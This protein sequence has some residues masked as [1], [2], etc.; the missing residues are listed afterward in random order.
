[1]RTAANEDFLAL[2]DTCHFLYSTLKLRDVKDQ[3]SSPI[4]EDFLPI[5]SQRFLQKSAQLACILQE[6]AQT[7]TLLYP[8]DHFSVCRRNLENEK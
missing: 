5:Y 8:Q 6:A 2:T 7:H 3:D 1:M 4:L